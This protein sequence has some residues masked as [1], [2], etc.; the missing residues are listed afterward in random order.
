MTA[1]VHGAPA[2]WPPP[3]PPSCSLPATRP[4]RRRR[5]SPRSLQRSRRRRIAADDLADPIAVFVG[6]GLASSNG[7]ARR[8]LAQRSFYANGA[9]ARRE[10]PAQRPE[11]G[12]RQVPPAAQGEEVAPP[13]RNIFLRVLQS[14]TGVLSFN[15]ASRKDK[16][17]RK[18]HSAPT[19]TAGYPP[20]LRKRNIPG[21]GAC[22]S[23]GS[24]KTEE[25]TERQ[26][27]QS[28][29]HP[30]VAERLSV[31]FCCRLPW[32]QQP[33]LPAVIRFVPSDGQ[34]SK[35]APSTRVFPDSE[36]AL[37]DYRC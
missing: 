20:N 4:P 10:L 1:L 7:D 24:L 31:N 19:P 12:A 5:R 22:L 25:K 26:C 8:S 14:T 9:A 21:H 28:D 3:K 17:L 27:G 33:W 13:R 30:R 16:L 2:A 35:D 36:G 23:F 15:S 34:H 11:T 18:G 29:V 37:A 6:A 32:R